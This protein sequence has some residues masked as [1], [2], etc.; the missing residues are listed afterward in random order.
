MNREKT[1]NR[2]SAIG[3][4][5]QFLIV[6]GVFLLT[7]CSHALQITNLNDYYSEPARPLKEPVKI[8]V[9]SSG[10]TSPQA[11]RYV[12]AVVEAIKKN[13][14][15][16]QVVYPYKQAEQKDAVDA[17][18]DISV[19]PKYSGR[20]S[21]F[22]VNFP[23]FLIFAPAIWGYG[24]NADINT[25]VNVTRLKDNSATNF[26]FPVNMISVTRR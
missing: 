11:G 24:Y 12:A 17:V 23:G 15:V 21:N 5:L 1:G 19:N 3:R 14:S 26:L 18:A 13:S 10:D 4:G 2:K 6:A 8:G 20:G 9:T 25:V 7:G 22:L 16:A